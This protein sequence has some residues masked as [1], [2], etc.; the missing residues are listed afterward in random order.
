MQSNHRF[1]KSD[2][3]IKPAINHSDTN[4]NTQLIDETSREG[5]HI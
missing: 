3:C 5:T 1:Y 2:T 4:D